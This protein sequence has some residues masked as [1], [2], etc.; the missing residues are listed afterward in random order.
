MHFT[1]CFFMARGTWMQF[2]VCSSGCWL[3]GNDALLWS[4]GFAVHRAWAVLTIP[5]ARPGCWIKLSLLLAHSPSPFLPSRA[6][7]AQPGWLSPYGCRRWLIPG[8][9]LTW[10]HSV[11]HFCSLIPP[12]SPSGWQPCLPPLG[13]H[14]WAFWWSGWSSPLFVC[15][16]LYVYMCVTWSVNIFFTIPVQQLDWKLDWIQQIRMSFLI[17]PWF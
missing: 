14:P 12:A 3:Q 5:A 7:A 6:A 8:L 9:G 17:K 2:S 10:W 1:V 15:L 13:C 4:P 11:W 16:C